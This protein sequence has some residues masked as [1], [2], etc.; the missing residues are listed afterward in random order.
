MLRIT[1]YADR[2]EKDLDQLNWPE[3]IK[4]LQRNWIGRSTGA[5]VD[6]FIG[7]FLDEPT[8]VRRSRN[9]RAGWSIGGGRLAAKA[10]RGGAA[11]LHH[12]A[13][14]AFRRHVHGDRAGASVRASG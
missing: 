13:R 1:A 11:D 7:T 3:S 8:A 2:L 4:L 9:T 5:E 6:F 14:H 12:P 10:R